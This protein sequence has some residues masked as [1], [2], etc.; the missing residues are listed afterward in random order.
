MLSEGHGTTGRALSPAL[1]SGHVAMEGF[2]EDIW[3]PIRR[4]ECKGHGTELRGCEPDE[5]GGWEGREQEWR[6]VYFTEQSALK[7][8][9]CCHKWKDL[10]LFHGRTVFHRVDITRSLSVSNVAV[11]MGCREKEAETE[12]EDRG[13]V[14]QGHVKDRQALLTPFC[15]RESPGDRVR[16]EGLT[17]QV[18]VRAR[19]L[20]F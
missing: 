20:P 17:Q 11:D 3:K 2:L 10:L 9:P 4:P 7:V 13:W 16:M 1:S 14:L 8:H 15:A 5:T 18:W 12:E 19:R 6:P